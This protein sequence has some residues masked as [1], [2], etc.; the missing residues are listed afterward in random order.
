MSGRSSMNQEGFLNDDHNY[1]CKFV[2]YRDGWHINLYILCETN[3]IV[4]SKS[5]M[6][7]IL[8]IRKI[9]HRLGFL[10]DDQ[11]HFW[12]CLRYREVQ[13]IDFKVLCKTNPMVWSKL[14]IDIII[15]V[16]KILYG[17]GRV[18]EG[19]LDLPLYIFELQRSIY[20]SICMCF[21]RHIQWCG[22]NYLWISSLMSGTSSNW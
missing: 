7:I 20:K 15:D 10:K 5:L 17:S 1:F 11:I 3:P 9:F 4:L 8:G 19:W 18:P 2:C 21:V 6:G 16:R 12:Q 22:Q 13:Y 14:L